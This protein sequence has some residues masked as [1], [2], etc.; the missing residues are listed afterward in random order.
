M[1]GTF[2]T[3]GGPAAWSADETGLEVRIGGRVR[4]TAWSEATAAALVRFSLVGAEV[5][6]GIVPGFGLLLALNR[7][8]AGMYGQLVVA[9]GPSSS[10]AVRVTVPLDGA[11]AALLVGAVRD[12]M[13]SRWRGEIPFAAHMAALGL[14]RPRWTLPAL[15]VALAAVGSVMLLAM[16]AGAAV[17]GGRWA[18]V[19]P[20]AWAGLALWLGLIGV[21]TVAAV[22]R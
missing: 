18:E 1:D 9:R 10:R 17:A 4:R 12:A 22:R 6:T 2:E 11:G 20:A 14:R 15:L 5:P 19:P 7:R 16:I 13:G 8:E 3:I 21:L